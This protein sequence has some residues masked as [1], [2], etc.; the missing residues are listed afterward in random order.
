MNETE[1]EKEKAMEQTSAY[2]DELFARP[3]PPML[4][5]VST[6]RVDVPVVFHLPGE[7]ISPVNG[8]PVNACVVEMKSGESFVVRPGAHLTTFVELGEGEMRFYLEATEHMGTALA[9]AMA[10]GPRCGVREP[11][12]AILLLVA[13]LRRQSS[14]LERGAREPAEPIDA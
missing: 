8:E 5:H 1:E 14:G 6:L 4:L 13:L 9:E 12:T 10:M 11:Q 7:Y 3:R 2:F